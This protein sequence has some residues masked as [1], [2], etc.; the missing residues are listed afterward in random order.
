[1]SWKR[2]RWDPLEQILL[3][4]G[5]LQALFEG[6]TKLKMLPVVDPELRRSMAALSWV[7]GDVQKCGYE[8]MITLTVEREIFEAQQVS[9]LN[10]VSK[11]GVQ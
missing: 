1:M 4:S 2:S 5:E 8:L 6:G 9:V 3:F 11:Y 7:K 10:C